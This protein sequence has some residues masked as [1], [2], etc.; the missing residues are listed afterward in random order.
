MLSTLA[1]VW[2]VA[3]VILIGLLIY[4]ALLSMKEDDQLFLS[5][6]EQH[7]EQEQQILV[8]KLQS[9]GRYSMILGILSVVL[10]LVIAGLWMYQELTRPP[11]S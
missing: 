9:I 6:G 1:L 8:G 4:R 5:A 11:I 10:L 7:L 2:A 3:T